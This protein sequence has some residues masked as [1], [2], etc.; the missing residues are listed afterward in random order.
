MGEFER[1]ARLRRLYERSSNAVMLGIG[2]DCAVLAPSDR[3]RVWT[4]DVAVSGVHFDLTFT[5]L[6]AAG[7]R[8]FMAAA[9]DLAAM[10]ARGVAALSSLVLPRELSDDELDRLAEGIARASDASSCPVVGGNLARGSELA[11][12]TSVLGECQGP[13]LRRDGARAGD[14]L[15]LTG[16]VGGAALGLVRLQKGLSIAEPDPFTQAFLFPRARLDLSP[17]LAEHASSAIDVSD[18]LYADLTHLCQASGVRAELELSRV[19]TLPGFARH[20]EEVGLDAS[21]LMLGGGD[22]YEVLFTAPRMLPEGLGTCIGKVSQGP[23]AVVV[24]DAQGQP[25]SLDQAGFDH[26]R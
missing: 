2:D 20:A 6:E 4:V 10:G 14:F 1:I 7:Y 19:P 3:P 15:Y 8:A 9:S 24:L 11:I 12:T 26:F 21:A 13:V 25:L 18:G 16:P 5:S 23:G 17:L 22:D